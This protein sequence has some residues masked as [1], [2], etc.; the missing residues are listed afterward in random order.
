M[1]S[2][3]NIGVLLR[4]RVRV[5]GPGEEGAGERRVGSDDEVGNAAESSTRPVASTAGDSTAAST[6]WPESA[7][8]TTGLAS[9]VVEATTSAA[10][11]TGLASNVVEAISSA[12]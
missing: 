3:V 11:T 2:S 8:S 7:A 12:G 6:T 4:E 5:A 1:V 10:S 9:K